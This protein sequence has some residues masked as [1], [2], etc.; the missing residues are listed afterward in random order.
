M[1]NPF[2]DLFVYSF[3]VPTLLRIAAAL[4]FIYIAQSLFRNRGS[5]QSV[6]LPL[7]QHARP[8]MMVLSAAITLVTAFLLFIGLATQYAAILGAVIALKHAFMLKQLVPIRPLPLSTNLL[9]AV[10]C[11]SLLVTGAGAFAFDLPL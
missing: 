10:I 5:V 7:I 9:L 6:Q 1:F 2:P 3:S 8:W 4:C 11:L